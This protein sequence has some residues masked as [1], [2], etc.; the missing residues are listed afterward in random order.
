MSVLADQS[1]PSSRH[2]FDH[3]FDFNQLPSEVI[4]TPGPS[5]S[6]LS[7]RRA[8]WRHRERKQ[9]RGK[10]GGLRAKLRLNPHRPALPSVFLGNVRSLLGRLE[11]FKISTLTQRRIMDY[12]LMFFTGGPDIVQSCPFCRSYGQGPQW[13]KLHL[14]KQ[15]VVHG[16]C[17]HGNLLLC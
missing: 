4:R 3:P 13:R 5:E 16:L 11:E 14:C 1:N 17:C 2:R 15:S 6:L 10:R 7:T 9:R 12:H 8:W